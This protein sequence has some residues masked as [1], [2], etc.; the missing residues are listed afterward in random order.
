MCGPGW[1]AYRLEE[2][3]QIQRPAQQPSPPPDVSCKLVTQLVELVAL[4]ADG[5]HGVVL[6]LDEPLTLQGQGAGPLRDRLWSRQR[7]AQ[8]GSWGKGA[9][10]PARGRQGWAWGSVGWDGGQ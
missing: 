5:V 3:V 8:P 7:P 1:G 4:G 2:A 10:F 6:Q 9:P